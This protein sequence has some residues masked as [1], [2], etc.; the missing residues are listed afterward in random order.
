MQFTVF[1]SIFKI[2]IL[3]PVLS[4][5]NTFIV[6]EIFI[7]STFFIFLEV[8]NLPLKKQISDGR[9]FEPRKQHV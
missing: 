6:G 5:K 1:I 9:K 3:F 2:K 8:L 7:N 4:D